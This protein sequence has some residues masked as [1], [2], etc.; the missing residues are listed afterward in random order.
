MTGLDYLSES[1]KREAAQHDRNVGS[2]SPDLLAAAF[3]DLHRRRVYDRKDQEQRWIM[4]RMAAL[5][6]LAVKMRER[7][8]A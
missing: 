5:A 6:R 7:G 1:Q 4:S 2:Y 8:V 3:D